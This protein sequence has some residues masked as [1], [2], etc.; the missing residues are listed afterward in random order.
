MAI[1]IAE[2][3]REDVPYRT[4]LDAMTDACRRL[5]RDGCEWHLGRVELDSLV[6]FPPDGQWMT[7]ATGLAI[8]EAAGRPLAET[9]VVAV[10]PTPVL[11]KIQQWHPAASLMA[12]FIPET[13][14]VFARQRAAGE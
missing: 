14:R 13:D 8:Q 12:E 1:A 9:L 7:T 2:V 10:R 11:Y 3:T 5:P 6:Q 4:R